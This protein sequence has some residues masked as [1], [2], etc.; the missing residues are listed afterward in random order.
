MNRAVLQSSAHPGPAQVFLDTEFIETRAG[1]VLISIGMVAAT[2]HFYGERPAD[3]FSAARANRF[4]REEVLPQFGKCPGVYGNE[5]EIAHGLVAWLNALSAE[6]VEV[7]YDFSLDYQLLEQLIALVDQPLRPRLDAV[8]IGYL[9]A[10][11]GG[12]E[13]AEQ[14]WA[15]TAASM[16]L[17]RHHALADAMA[18]RARFEAVHRS[19]RGCS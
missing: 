10:D 4:V 8:H 17:H 13:A 2:T 11:A 19:P 14:S 16:G 15:A 6:R 1:P 7:H 3:S 9:L 18:L 5:T 12:T